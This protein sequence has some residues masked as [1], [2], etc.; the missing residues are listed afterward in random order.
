MIWQV[1][2]HSCRS[3]TSMPSACMIRQV[4]WEA[5]VV[6]GVVTAGAGR[7][8][9]PTLKQIVGPWWLAQFD[10]YPDAARRSK[11]AFDTCFP[12]AKAREA[13]L[14]CRAQ[15]CHRGSSLKAGG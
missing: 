2:F 15:V 4:R 14:F 9:A 5:A 7:G 6:N 10:L 12:G 8:L 1:H 11:A 13:L 3:T